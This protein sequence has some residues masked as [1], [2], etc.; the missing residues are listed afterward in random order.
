MHK[1]GC[2]SVLTNSNHSLVYLLYNEFDIQVIKSKRN[3]SSKGDS[4]TG[5]DTIV[6]KPVN[7]NQNMKPKLNP[8]PCQV[9][10]FP[11]TR[12]MGS[13]EGILHHIWEATNGLK[14]DSVLDLFS[15]SGIVGYMFK[16]GGKKVYCNDYMAMC[17]A[18]G[19]ALVENNSVTLTEYDVELLL[20]EKT[21]GDNFVQSTFENLYFNN[22]D[23]RTIDQI[24]SN[25]NSLLNRKK[26]AIAT[27]ALVRAC[28]KKRP[29]GVFTYVGDRYDDGRKDLKLSIEDHFRDAVGLIN[30]AVFDNGRNNRA[31]WGDALTVRWKPDLVY[32]DP[33]YYSPLS[34]NEYVRR[35]H[36]VEGLARNWRGVELQWHTKTRKFKSYPTPFSSREGATYA[37]N[38]LFQRFKNSIIIVSYSSNSLPSLEEITTLMAKHKDQVSVVSLDHRYSF[39]NQNHKIDDNKNR[40][41]EYLFIGT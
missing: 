6:C 40:V 17:E 18:V 24:R 34:D 28:M 12:F 37:F 33:P 21:E 19:T 5:T 31:R 22:E 39:G 2:S 1:I 26:R 29:R 25:I 11:P 13:K 36:F 8:M 41:K 32:I 35:Y 27:S 15:G 10:K 14:F 7:L 30:S 9:S 16:S 38:Q 20:H 3:I 4:R 23:N